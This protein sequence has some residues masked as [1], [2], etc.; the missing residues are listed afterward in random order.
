MATASLA[1]HNL[2][3]ITHQKD[4]LPDQKAI[5]E[6]LIPAQ[7]AMEETSQRIQ[8]A[9]LFS[10]SAQLKKHVVNINEIVETAYK[11]LKA[12]L[13]IQLILDRNI[14]FSLADAKSLALVL[15]ELARIASAPDD[16][17]QSVFIKTYKGSSA[18]GKAQT[19][20][21]IFPEPFSD[22]PDIPTKNEFLN[23]KISADNSQL[24]LNMALILLNQNQV[25][26]YGYAKPDAGSYFR[27]IFKNLQD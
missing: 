1:L 14:D 22:N 10:K 27:L 26:F 15:E 4:S 3:F 21:H 24:M 7:E 12:S 6:F 2:Y 13:A 23:S 25:T 9:V 11:R 17:Q 20:V 18:D 19:E 8:N 16:G 5:D